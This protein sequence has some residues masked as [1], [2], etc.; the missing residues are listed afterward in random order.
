MEKKW[1]KAIFFLLTFFAIIVAGTV[2]KILESFLKPVTISVLLS[3]VFFPFARKLNIKCRIPW[4]LAITIIYLIFFAF[5]F[6]VG[7]IIA[8]SIKS[9]LFSLP[10]YEE[11]FISIF[12][13]ITE[14]L[15]GNPNNKVLFLFDFEADLSIIE[16]IRNQLNLAPTLQK[17]AFNF[18]ETFISFIKNTFLVL[19][20]SIF[21]LAEMNIT[22]KKINLAFDEHNRKKVLQIIQNVTSDITHY[23]SIKFII[24]LLTGFLVTLLCI[25]IRLDFPLVWGFLAFTMNFIPTFGSIISCGITIVFALIQFFPLFSP[26]LIISVGLVLINII[27]GNIIEPKIEGENLGLSSFIILVS[28]SLWGWLW[29]FMGLLIAVP[30]TV[31][32]KIFCENMSVLHPIAILMGNKKLKTKQSSENNI[33]TE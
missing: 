17:F 18:T 23:I 21:L 16:N 22:R 27:L 2:L 8:A 29:G 10:R 30:L 26:V 32:I 33:K 5:F 31:I 20:F 7:D 9:I 12:S 3:F 14:K 25:A 13:A 15:S 19:L 6:V 28:L 4:W 24:S 1:N 11:R